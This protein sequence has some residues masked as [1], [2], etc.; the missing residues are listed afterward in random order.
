MIVLTAISSS[1]MVEEH[2]NNSTKA[3]LWDSLTEMLALLNASSVD[4]FKRVKITDLPTG[5]LIEVKH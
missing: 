3:D 5:V 1:R 2:D 4:E